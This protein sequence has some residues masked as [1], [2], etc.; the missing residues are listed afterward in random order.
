MKHEQHKKPILNSY[1]HIF[2]TSLR[3][4]THYITNSIFKV[5][6]AINTVN[7]VTTNVVLEKILFLN[8]L[9][10]SLDAYCEHRCDIKTDKRQTGR[11]IQSFSFYG[12]GRGDI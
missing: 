5:W 3:N 6:I 4:G 2:R 11:H 9:F 7:Y 10:G 8:Y 1:K 12:C